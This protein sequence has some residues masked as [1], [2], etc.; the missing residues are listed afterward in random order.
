MK[1]LVFF[2]PPGVGK[3]TQAAILKDKYNLIHISTGDVFRDNIKNKTELG[4]LAKSY[5]DV[6]N[7]VPDKVTIDMLKAE[8]NKSPNANGF[9]L[10]GFPRTVSQAKALD[11]FLLEKGKIINGMVSI[12]VPEDLLVKRILNRGL[13]S[14][15]PDDQNVDK[16]KHRFKEYQTKTAILQEYFQKQNKYYGIDGVGSIDEITERLSNVIDNL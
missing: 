10:D 8:V 15:R 16:I 11:E 9:I 4:K 13:T 5:M 1:N 3:G 6:G 12:V 7:L 14:G 2:G